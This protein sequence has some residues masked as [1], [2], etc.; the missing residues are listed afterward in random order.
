MNIVHFVTNEDY[1]ANQSLAIK[2]L[3]DDFIQNLLRKTSDHNRKTFSSHSRHNPLF[4]R[5]LSFLISSQKSTSVTDFH[6]QFCL[7]LSMFQDI[8]YSFLILS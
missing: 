2:P 1:E 7:I 3:R 8:S 6:D 4:Q 5:Q